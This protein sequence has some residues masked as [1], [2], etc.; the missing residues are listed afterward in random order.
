V[1]Y[2]S[3]THTTDE[4]K[5]QTRN[6]FS[7]PHIYCRTEGQFPHRLHTALFCTTVTSPPVGV[8]PLALSTEKLYQTATKLSLF[9]GNYT[10][11]TAR[12]WGFRGQ[13]FGKYEENMWEGT[14]KEHGLSPTRERLDMACYSG[15]KHLLRHLVWEGS[16]LRHCT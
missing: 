16:D 12:E 15:W 9:L 3:L 13:I 11:I 7:G 8:P 5:N 14:R 2:T 1:T 4:H 10:R 6:I